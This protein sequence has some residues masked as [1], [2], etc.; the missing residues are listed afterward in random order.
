MTTGSVLDKVRKFKASRPQQGQN[1]HMRGIFADWKEGDNIVRLAGEFLEVR[2]HFI[3]P[4]PKR[5]ERGLCMPVAFQGD[6]KLP[7]VVNCWDWDV[8]REEMK[9]EK[10]CPICKLRAIAL[11]ILHENPTAEEKE[12]F[13]ALMSAVSLR[14]NVKWNIID[15][16]DPY[17]MMVENG[18]EQKVLGFKIATFGMEAYGDIEGIFD[19]VQQDITDPDNGIDIK[20]H[21]GH[22]GTRTTYTA[23]A[24]VAGTSLKVTPFSEEERAMVLHDL[25]SVCGKVSDID[26][27]VNAMHEDIRQLLEVNM[28]DETAEE[29][30]AA[31]VQVAEEEV[32]P[33]PAPVPAPKPAP[34]AARPAPVA[35]KPA[36]VA[37]KPAPVAAPVARPA[38]VAARPVAAPAPRPA[39]RPAA[40]PARPVAAPAPRPVQRPAP[41]PVAKPAAVEAAVD[42]AIGAEDPGDGLMDG[43]ES[44]K[45]T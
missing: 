22:N 43:T 14:R 7:Q 23:Q 15:R 31:E 34:V 40:A 9:H 33:A 41:R 29:G 12:Y 44:Q 36:P 3:A 18:Q 24:C 8:D 25:K 37:A 32:A 10:T 20:V 26:K 1:R 27:V 45:K 38:P 39:A 30:V 42:D 6:D 19:Q 21:R 17:V 2:T 28:T 16:A 4:A 5:Q 11:S 35:A 13:E